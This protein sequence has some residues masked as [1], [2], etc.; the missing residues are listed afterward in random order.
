[1]ENKTVKY[2]LKSS[3]VQQV[4]QK[5]PLRLIW[6][7][8]IIILFIITGS[9]GLLTLITIPEKK[10]T[11]VDIYPAAPGIH[12]QQ[13]I[14]YTQLGYRDAKRI[15]TGAPAWLTVYNNPSGNIPLA[16]DSIEVDSIRL[17]RGASLIAIYAHR[18]A[19]GIAPVYYSQYKNSGL[20]L[21]VYTEQSVA[22][23]MADKLFHL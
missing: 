4:L 7:G 13:L 18:I 16:A 22:R 23:K 15:K 12:Q 8:N 2:E 3:E 11:K 6:W 9:I 10:D 1:M 17:Y 20:L 5:A 14:L 21:L 19:P